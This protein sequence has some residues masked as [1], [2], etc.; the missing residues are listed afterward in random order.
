MS[1]AEIESKDYLR[2]ADTACVAG[3]RFYNVY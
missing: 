3:E 1:T 2:A